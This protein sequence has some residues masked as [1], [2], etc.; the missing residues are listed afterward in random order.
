MSADGYEIESTKLLTSTK[1]VGY[2]DIL[3]NVD[4]LFKYTL[5]YLISGNTLSG[6]DVALGEN[7]FIESGTCDESS[8][9]E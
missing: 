4:D 8:S 1:G 7:Y 6:K 3:R 2:K 9:P 5:T